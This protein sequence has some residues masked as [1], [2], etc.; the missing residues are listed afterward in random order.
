MIGVR[1]ASRI[2]WVGT[3][4]TRRSAENAAVERGAS[5]LRCQLANLGY[6]ISDLRF[7]IWE[8]TFEK[9][10][11]RFGTSD[12]RSEISEWRLRISATLGRWACWAWSFV[13][14]SVLV[15]MSFGCE[16]KEASPASSSPPPPSSETS[17]ASAGG[18]SSADDREASQKVSDAART[19]Q[20]N[21]GVGLMGKFDFEAARV[22]FAE[23]V[24]ERPEWPEAKLN[25]AIATLNR[26]QE[27]DSEAAL[28]LLGEILAERPE[29]VRAQY[30]A[31]LVEL[32]E[33]R[34]AE[35]LGHFEFVVE[36]EPGD[37][38]AAYFA[39]QCLT[40]L[41][42]SERAY[43]LYL[44][45]AEID[46]Y[47]RSAYYAAGTEARRLG[48]RE[49]A[50]ELLQ[51]FQR[52]EPNPRSRTVEFKY[53]RMGA[54]GE[55]VAG[56]SSEA[57]E[58]ARPE[59][60]LFGAARVMAEG[61]GP[62]R[63]IT[64]CDIDGDGA[65]DVLVCGEAGSRVLRGSGQGLGMAT[66]PAFASTDGVRA[67]LWGD[68][69]ND[70]RVDLYLCRDGANQLWRSG[71][72]GSWVDLTAEAGVGG[73]ATRSM[74]GALFDAD[75]DGDLD[76]FVV[77]DG[78]NE[79]LSN[80]GDGTFRRL[81]EE[82]G[83]TGGDRASRGVVFADLD[84]DR[85]LDIFVVHEAPPHEVFINDLLWSYRPGGEE[86]A[87]L[88]EAPAVAAVAADMDAGGFVDL[89]TATGDGRVLE[90]R[91]DEEGR[92]ES[93]VLWGQ[94]NGGDHGAWRLAVVD[95][96]GDGGLDVLVLNREG[97]YRV[98]TDGS[99]AAQRLIDQELY[100]ATVAVMEADRGPS[101]V[102]LDPEK[103]IVEY[104]PGPGRYGFASLTLSGM[105]DPG[106]SMRSNASGIGVKVEARVA[107]RW[108]VVRSG[109]QVSGPGQS[110]QPIAIGLGGAEQIDFVRMEWPDG[111]MQTEVALAGGE[112]H[113]I[114]ETQR[115][116][117]SC[118][119]LF[120]WDGERYAFVS[121]LLGVGG[122]GYAVAPGEYAPPRPRENFLLP[123]GVARVDRGGSYRLMLAEPMEEACYLDVVGLK[124]V[125]VPP[126][127]DVVLDERMGILGPA[128][129]G[130]MVFFRRELVVERAWSE[131]GGRTDTAWKAVPPAADVTEAVREVDL[132]PVDPGRLD[133]RFI[134]MLAGE[135]V[136]T[137]EFAE[138]LDAGPGEPWLVGDGWVEYPYSQ[139]NF[140]AWQAGEA[141]EA[142]TLEARDADGEWHVV[143]EQFGYPAGMPRRMAMP[144][145]EGLPEGTTGLRLRTNQ[146]V[147]WDRLSVVFAEPCP[148]AR[149]RD[150]AME[151]ATLEQVGF[152]ERL[153]RRWR[154]PAYDYERRA[155]FWD[156]RYQRGWYTAFGEVGELVRE[157]DEG[158]C[159]FGPGEAVV[160]SFSDVGEAPEAGWR[161][162]LVLET[163][164]WCKD[165]DLYTDTG[166]T[167][168]PMPT[169]GE[170]SRDRAEELHERYNTRFQSGR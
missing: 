66:R 46:P 30:C 9:S 31:G 24:E 48:D 10:G 3:Q 138:A 136:L 28:A 100:G 118:P 140:A 119:V 27:G 146:E 157:H 149:V 22:V 141:Y 125:D 101:I 37:A 77:N 93:R 64:M 99:G 128:P 126:G 17:S 51:Q 106:Q 19:R 139:T 56:P 80:N 67:G 4:R 39:G 83:L 168:A 165:M 144:L 52:L 29:H 132:L 167:I 116:L 75:H 8:S 2:R 129:S 38:Y 135:H 65:L 74:A 159:V 112:T 160:M 166:E 57:V 113:E 44:R 50:G 73:G 108:T 55:V 36:R 53:T 153:D 98:A 137:L 163:R 115:Q 164:G 33:G 18:E 62:A 89:V 143:H 63:D 47:L 61:E 94:R 134:G 91:R 156:T 111:V 72:D 130:E 90:W 161:R 109:G 12:L 69:D 105:E 88:V 60:E 49:R 13:A 70:G 121:D 170:M 71:E 122:I 110:L 32:Y 87:A 40:N 7:E 35:A 152:P 154:I 96:D 5:G 20:M 82:R 148:E 103:G 58:A 11:S 158:V 150:L 43:E 131:W 16:K 114:S 151:R 102:G 124:A 23:L 162:R 95:V 123:E 117:S 155:P 92:F 78:P 25:L 54:L 120:V 127:W 147:Y 133:R 107:D 169:E 42:E 59:G 104:P 26:Q 142:P 45:A 81:A 86:Y 34:P 15:L 6:R 41:R 21:L 84:S 79:L 85:D 97:V 14:L 68:V 145:G 76:I 1:R